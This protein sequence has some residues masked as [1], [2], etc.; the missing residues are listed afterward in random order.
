MERGGAKVSLGGVLRRDMGEGRGRGWDLR[1]YVVDANVVILDEDFSFLG[2]WD[3]EIGLIFEDFDTACL[4]DDDAL[5]C[6]R[7]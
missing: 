4:L 3:W 5:H 2:L 6:F 1:V 7:Y